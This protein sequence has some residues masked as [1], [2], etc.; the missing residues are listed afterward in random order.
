MNRQRRNSRIQ[1]RVTLSNATKVHLTQGSKIEEITS[2]SGITLVGHEDATVAQKPKSND[3]N[4]LS[5][6]QKQQLA[7]AESRE[8]IA[9]MHVEVSAHGQELGKLCGWSLLFSGG[10]CAEEVS[11]KRPWPEVEVEAW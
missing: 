6:L 11:R 4:A 3:L 7:I 5:T 1:A 10:I 9:G 8:G 2:S